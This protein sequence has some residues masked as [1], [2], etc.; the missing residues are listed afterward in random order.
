MLSRP[1]V[2]EDD[3]HEAS[4]LLNRKRRTNFELP[5]NNKL[6]KNTEINKI[7]DLSLNEKRVCVLNGNKNA[8]VQELQKILL[9]F[10]ATIV[11]NPSKKIKKRCF[12]IFF[13]LISKNNRFCCCNEFKKCALCS[14]NQSKF[15]EYC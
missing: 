12:I 15:M 4:L 3:L 14:C 7:I 13:F 1:L 10:G 9:S 6:I 2:N 5:E 8:N 11:A